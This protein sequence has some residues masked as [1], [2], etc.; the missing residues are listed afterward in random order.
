M[1]A[2]SA[3]LIWSGLLTYCSRSTSYDKFILLVTVAKMSLF[4]LLS[5]R[6]NYI[7]LSSLPGLSKAG[8]KVSALLVDMITF[9]FTFCSKPSIWF[10]NSINTL[11]T[12]LSAPV[13]ASKRLRLHKKVL[14]CNRIDLID[15]DDWRLIFLCQLEDV[16]DHSWTLAQILL[17]EFWTDDSDECGSGV[18]SNGFCHHGL[19]CTWRSVHKNSL[20]WIDTDLSVKFGV[21]KRQLNGFSHLLFLDIKTTDIRESNIGLLLDLHH[22]DGCI[23]LRWQNIDNGMTVSVHGDTGWW[24]ELFPVK[25]GQNSNVVVCSTC[26]SD[27]TVVFVDHFDKMSD[28]QRYGLNSLQFFLGSELLS[29]E[30]YLIVLDVVF[31][32]CEEL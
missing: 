4:C 3:A 22:L 7:F 31:L 32:D 28:D 14:G 23:G 8:S 6:G 30:L 11:W 2:M 27:Q 9:T 12:S 15:E 10:N 13:W 24:L 26:G 18:I 20:G 17:Y 1:L 16:S 19:S 5:G 21:S 29:L 25:S